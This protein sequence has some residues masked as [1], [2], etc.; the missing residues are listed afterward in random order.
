MNDV[1]C[2]GS[3]ASLFSCSHTT[4]HNCGHHEDA[5]VQCVP[6]KCDF[7]CKHELEVF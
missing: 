7:S 5:G 3:E 1:A 4:N 6:R 2:T